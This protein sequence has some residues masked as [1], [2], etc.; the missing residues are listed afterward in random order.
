MYIS[1]NIKTTKRGNEQLSSMTNNHLITMQRNAGK[2]QFLH[3][4]VCYFQICHPLKNDCRPCSLPF[5]TAKDSTSAHD[6]S[7]HRHKSSEAAQGTPQR[8][9]GFQSSPDPNQIKQDAQVQGWWGGGHP[10]FNLVANQ[11]IA[12]RAWRFSY[13]RVTSGHLS[14]HFN[15][16]NSWLLIWPEVIKV[17]WCPS[18]AVMAW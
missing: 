8:P 15:Y 4:C 17:T 14:N 2:P 5:A 3:S 16:L 7:L 18:N 12:A 6:A 9:R 10:S 13:L 1:Q 11:C